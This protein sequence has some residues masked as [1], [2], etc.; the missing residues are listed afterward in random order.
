M[1][2]EKT[3]LGRRI[4]LVLVKRLG[5][6]TLGLGYAIALSD[7]ALAPFTPS[8]TARSAGTI[9]P[10]I[11]SIPELYGSAPGESARAGSARI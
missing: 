10:V 2:Y 7:L 1:G 9:F 6:R 5:G 4:A 3:G 8:N 11:R